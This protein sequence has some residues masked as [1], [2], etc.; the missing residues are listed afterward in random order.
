MSRSAALAAIGAIRPKAAGAT[1]NCWK[2][3]IRFLTRMGA[4]RRF[5]TGH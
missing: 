2:S 5:N 4:M 1:S 3:F